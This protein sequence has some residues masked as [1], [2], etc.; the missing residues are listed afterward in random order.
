MRSTFRGSEMTLPPVE[1]CFTFPRPEVK[2]CEGVKDGGEIKSAKGAATKIYFS[3]RDPADP[4][5]AEHQGTGELYL[6]IHNS[7]DKLL[8]AQYAWDG[9]AWPGNEFWWPGRAQWDASGDPAAACCSTIGELQNPYINPTMLKN[10]QVLKGPA[11][12]SQERSE[13]TSDSRKKKKGRF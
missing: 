9:N 12:A 1:V 11:P 10:I 6:S 5:P 2:F 8:V 7:S 13:S 4:L 3:K